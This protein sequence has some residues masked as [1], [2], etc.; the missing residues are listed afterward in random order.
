MCDCRSVLE[1]KLLQRVQN[2]N[3][4][5]TG[6]NIGLGGYVYVIGGSVGMKPSLP[7]E[8]SFDLPTKSGGTKTKRI[9]ERMIASYCP[10][11]GES[12][13]GEVA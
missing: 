13:I 6:I 3:P 1:K 9:K 12:L 5:A 4:E 11:C 2:A 8:G 10:F 7:I